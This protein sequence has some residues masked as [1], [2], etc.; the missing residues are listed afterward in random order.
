MP[1]LSERK[2]DKKVLNL[3]LQAFVSV[4]SDCKTDASVASFLD[5]ILTSTEKIMLAKRLGAVIMLQEGIPTTKIDKTLKL[6]RM[7]IG[8]IK[9]LVHARESGY[10]IALYKLRRR[11]GWENLKKILLDLA[12]KR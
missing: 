10:K 1:H 9:L 6:T 2:I 4:L 3:L 12:R 5:T 7:T 11:K 8:K